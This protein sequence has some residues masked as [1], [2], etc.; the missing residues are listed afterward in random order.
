MSGQ[1]LGFG[2]A[3]FKENKDFVHK[4]ANRLQPWTSFAE[5]AEKLRLL[6]GKVS[7]MRN[8]QV[9]LFPYQTKVSIIYLRPAKR[10]GLSNSTKNAVCD[11]PQVMKHTELV[12]YR[13]PNGLRDVSVEW[14]A[15]RNHYL[16]LDP[17]LIQVKEEF[18]QLRL[19]GG[20]TKLDRD[21]PV[22]QRVGS[23]KNGK[24]I[25]KL[26]Q[27]KNA[28]KILHRPSLVVSNQVNFICRLM[29]PAVSSRNR[30]ANMKVSRQP[31]LQTIKGSFVSTDGR[32]SFLYRWTAISLPGVNEIWL[33]PK[34]LIAGSAMID[35][36]SNL[37]SARG[38]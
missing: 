26:I 31:F 22:I 25:V 16:R 27:G 10:A 7:W 8:K 1:D 33:E 6:L 20:F 13:R 17:K 4:S 36:N 21:C 14:R 12:P 2:L 5:V 3:W 30:R 34:E 29:K 19:V 15:I 35:A 23:D 32:D 18:E 11:G 24:S 9:A 28:R 37:D 38:V